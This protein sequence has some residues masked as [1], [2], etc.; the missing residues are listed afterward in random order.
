MVTTKRTK[1]KSKGRIMIGEL[2]TGASNIIGGL[3]GAHAQKESGN[4]AAQ[5]QRETNAMQIDLANTAHQREIA[6]LKAAGLN[7]LLSGTGGQGASTPTLHAPTQSAEGSAKSGAIMGNAISMLPSQIMQYMQG[8]QQIEL[9]RANAEKIEAETKKI[10]AEIPWISPT[11]N[12]NLKE[13]E[14]RITESTQRTL[15]SKART[16]TTEA[17]REP[18]VK[19]L[20]QLIAKNA[21][22]TKTEE[23][24]TKEMTEIANNAKQLWGSRASE[25]KTIAEQAAT[26]YKNYF[27]T[28]EQQKIDKQNLEIELL[29]NEKFLKMID[30]I[31][32]NEYGRQEIWS[33]M[34]NNPFSGGAMVGGPKQPVIKDLK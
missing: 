30:V 8:Q 10:E 29:K 7:P 2:I 28:S 33:K 1:Q 11:Q 32:K 16:A 4:Q 34:F 6:D 31:L 19:N 25:A 23:Q 21:Q 17:M 24:R 15:E 22:E 13:G 26:Y 14:Q 12:L 27:L 20:V 5:I 18:Q 9:Q 3:I